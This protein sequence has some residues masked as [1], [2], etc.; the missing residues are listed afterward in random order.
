MPFGIKNPLSGLFKSAK[1]KMQ[2]SSTRTFVRFFTDAG[3]KFAEVQD[4]DVTKLTLPENTHHFKFFDRTMKK[5]E[6]PDTRTLFNDAEN[7]SP[8][9]YVVDKVMTKEAYADMPAEERSQLTTA[10]NAATLMAGA[11]VAITGAETRALSPGENNVVAIDRQTLKQLWP[12]VEDGPKS[13]ITH[14]RPKRSGA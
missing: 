11:Y 7:V 12:P 4:R 10:V 8:T 3:A 13:S 6:E 14:N 5:G 2:Q 1:D 9:H